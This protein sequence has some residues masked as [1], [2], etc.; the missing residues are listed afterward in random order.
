MLQETCELLLLHIVLLRKY[1]GVIAGLFVCLFVC[2]G[3][4]KVMNG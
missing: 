1:G 4:C 2:C 3:C